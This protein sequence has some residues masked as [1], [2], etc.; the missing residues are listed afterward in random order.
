M[1]TPAPWTIG[2]PRLTA[3][4]A[5]PV[6]DVFMGAGDDGAIVEGASAA[7]NARLI[8]ASPALVEALQTILRSLEFEQQM[9]GQHDP[10]RST[11][12][13]PRAISIARAALDK[14]TGA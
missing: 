13:F 9:Y 1:H 11:I 5:Q 8:A 12:D 4:T 3:L 10:R 14:A 7:A 2:G 6:Y